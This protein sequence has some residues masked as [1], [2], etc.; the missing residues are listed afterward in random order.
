[1]PLCWNRSSSEHPVFLSFVPS[2]FF[3]QNL[4]IS[5][6]ASQ[7]SYILVSDVPLLSWPELSLYSI[8]TSCC[9]SFSVFSSH[10]TISSIHLILSESQIFV[11]Q[12]YVHAI[13]LDSIFFF[14][15]LRS[16]SLRSRFT[17]PFHLTSFL[18]TVRR[19]WLDL[20]FHCILDLCIF[21]F[22]FT[23]Y[24]HLILCLPILIGRPSSLTE[25][26]C[27]LLLKCPCLNTCFSLI[28]QMLFSKFPQIFHFVFD[29]S[30]GYTKFYF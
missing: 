15:C 12:Q 29:C 18:A 9:L 3:P 13:K 19:P 17:I 14:A 23:I 2:D 24:L 11:G 22:I 27:F 10:L 26:S 5:F 28:S 16:T 30:Y 8:C 6:S 25:Y 4:S 7:P 21:R 20:P 1:M